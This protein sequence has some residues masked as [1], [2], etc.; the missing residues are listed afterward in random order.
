M[1]L[2]VV[3]CMKIVSPLA[4]G[5]Y[6]CR[7]RRGVRKRH[8]PGEIITKLRQVCVGTT[9]GLGKVGL[10]D[11][12][13]GPI[14]GGAFAGRLRVRVLVIAPELL[15]LVAFGADVLVVLSVPFKVGAEVFA[16]QMMKHLEECSWSGIFL[17]R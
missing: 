1:R 13:K 15:Q 16:P 10:T 11:L 5:H 8:K 6:V 4:L 2:I 9:L 3:L 14:A 12:F 17:E 7:E